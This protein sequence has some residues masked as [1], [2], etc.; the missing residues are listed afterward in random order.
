METLQCPI[1]GNI[2]R[3]MTQNMDFVRYDLSDMLNFFL[4][5]ISQLKEYQE[6]LKTSKIPAKK[7]YDLFTVYFNNI[8]QLLD[9]SFYP[10]EYKPYFLTSKINDAVQKLNTGE[11]DI[12]KKRY[13]EAINNFSNYLKEQSDYLKKL[14]AIINEMKSKK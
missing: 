12:D 7:I 14:N 3:K 4:R 6:A 1:M 8:N 9:I 11:P 13:D 5:N 10:I 2:F